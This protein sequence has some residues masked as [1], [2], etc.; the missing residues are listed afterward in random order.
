MA[1]R[2]RARLKNLCREHG[3][4]GYADKLHEQMAKE[5]DRSVIG[6]I[7]TLLNDVLKEQVMK[8]MPNLNSE[9]RDKLFGAAK[10][11]GSFATLTDLSYAMG[12]IGKKEYDALSI[13][14]EMRNACAH[15]GG[16]LSFETHEI[17]ELTAF[18]T[19]YA[20]EGPPPDDPLKE[21]T[22][23]PVKSLGLRMS[24]IMM[25]YLIACKIIHFFDTKG[26]KGQVHVAL[27]ALSVAEAV[28]F[29]LPEK[30][31]QQSQRANLPEDDTA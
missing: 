22:D 1:K 10:P 3:V 23:D 7:A 9:L 12:W 31:P 18:L 27:G 4:E 25:G 2:A 20:L 24:F 16:S 26:G 21:L 8:K 14:R 6:L 13:V 15:Y 29:S 11:L 5:S 19:F 17:A 28:V 30:P